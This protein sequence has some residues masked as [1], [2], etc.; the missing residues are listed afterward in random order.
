MTAGQKPGP[1]GAELMPTAGLRVASSFLTSE[2]DSCHCSH[3]IVV[4]S[5]AAFRWHPGDDLVGVGDVAGFAVHAVRGDQA[6]ALAVRLRRVIYHFVHICGTEILT[7]AAEFFHAARVANICVVNDQVRGLVFFV[8]GA[9]VV[10]VGEL[11]ESKLAVTFGGGGFGGSRRGV[12]LPMVPA[13]SAM[14]WFQ[15]GN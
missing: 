14:A 5:T 13:V 10:E 11:I 6:D 15:R 9:R 4:R 2:V 8:L 3:P 1:P 12:L 7:G